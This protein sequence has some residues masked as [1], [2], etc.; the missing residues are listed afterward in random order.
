M[1]GCQL[2]ESKLDDACGCIEKEWD[3]PAGY[4]SIH[5]TPEGYGEIFFDNGDAGEWEVQITGKDHTD[6]R[7][8][9]VNYIGSQAAL[10]K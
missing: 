1:D 4:M 10:V 9:L 7:R 3:T 6:F 8:Q 2:I 5:L